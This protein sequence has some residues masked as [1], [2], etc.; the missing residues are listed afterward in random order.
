MGWL[1]YFGTWP[2]AGAWLA[3]HLW[4]HYL[5]TGDK[6]F[7][8][9][10][11]PLMES[12]ARFF[13]DTLVEHPEK[14]WLVTCPSNSPE[15][16]YKAEG[17]PRQWDRERFSRGEITTICAGPTIDMQILGY[18]F[19]ACIEAADI[20]GQDG[21]LSRRISETRKRVAPMQI[22]RNGQLQEW[23]KD[24]DDPEDAHRHV[25]HLWGLYPGNLITLEKT[26]DLA[27]AAKTS[28]LQRGDGGTGWAMAWKLNLW[29]RLRE[30]EH[31]QVILNNLFSLEGEH[32]A[33]GGYRGG[34]LSNLF[35][36][37]PPYQI[38]GNF[39]GKAG[40]AEI[41]L[42]SHDGAIL[43][44]PALPASLSQGQAAGLRA[45]GGFEVD[46]A[47][48]RGK[49]TGATIR[50]L[51]GRDC[52]LRSGVP[53]SVTASGKEIPTVSPAEGIFQFPTAQGQSYTLS[54]RS[55]SG[56]EGL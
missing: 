23:L 34:V 43:L 40:I 33:R 24:W 15:N 10:A 4:E 45:R 25:S 18:L 2:T 5:F 41:L 1:G 19:D 31:V 38:D 11:Y 42:Q 6:D 20:L 47:W 8:R 32:F 49:L 29:A 28:L 46:M 56:S 7:L 13:L 35:I 54:F 22:G 52:L 30:P 55:E 17:S 14:K 50:S 51:L 27:E 3:T 53:V 21:D 48:S 37:H 36:N 9:T 44:L 39:G 16:W 12:A 26:P